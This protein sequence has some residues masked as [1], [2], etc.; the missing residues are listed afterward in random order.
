[1]D[2]TQSKAVELTTGEREE[3]EIP[4]QDDYS[5]GNY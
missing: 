4:E 3:D 1:M 5:E 2:W